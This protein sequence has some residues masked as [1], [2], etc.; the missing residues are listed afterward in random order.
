M[1]QAFILA[2]SLEADER[3]NDG[4]KLLFLDESLEIDGATLPYGEIAEIEK[5]WDPSPERNG[6]VRVRAKRGGPLGRDIEMYYRFGDSRRMELSLEYALWKSG[7]RMRTFPG[8]QRSG[9]RRP[10]SWAA[11]EV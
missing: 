9:N 8:L 1:R 3:Y 5:Q 10:M 4:K 7:A 2:D 11:A 6:L